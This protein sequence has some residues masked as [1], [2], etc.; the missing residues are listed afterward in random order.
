MRYPTAF[1]ALVLLA[2]A[3]VATA[4]TSEEHVAYD[5]TVTVSE[6][7]DVKSEERVKMSATAFLRWK[8]HYGSN[9]S[10]FKRDCEKEMSQDEITDFKLEQND[11]DREVKVSF[12]TKGAVHSRGEGR[13]AY[14]IPDKWRGGNSSGDDYT[15]HYAE[16]E[17]PGTIGEHSVR[18]KFAPG[19]ERLREQLRDDSEKVIEYRL[20]PNQQDLIRGGL[21]ILTVFSVLGGGFLIFVGAVLALVAKRADEA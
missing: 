18:L 21:G 19:I 2:A 6:K 3:P 9:P 13:L 4:Q 11:L 12:V 20:P 15:F 10:I 5:E 17:G 16:S 8:S 7:G 1:V 14:S